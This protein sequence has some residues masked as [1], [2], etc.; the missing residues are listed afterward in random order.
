MEIDEVG[1]QPVHGGSYSN[2][3]C[4]FIDVVMQA[5]LS[6]SNTP[7]TP[8]QV[9]A[10][11]TTAPQGKTDVKAPVRTDTWDLC[12]QCG[13]HF[14]PNLCTPVGGVKCMICTTQGGVAANP[15]P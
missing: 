15:R 5:A 10:S 8:S 3:Q 1:G 13:I 6:S 12:M 11:P 14:W 4:T 9:A 7:S 2:D